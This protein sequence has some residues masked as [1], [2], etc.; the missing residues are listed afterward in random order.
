MSPK[1]I[2]IGF[3]LLMLGINQAATAQDTAETLTHDGLERTYRLH[4]PSSYDDATA[5]P[6][7]IALHPSGGNGE[8]MA[9]ITGLNDVAE[10][11]NFI[12][13][14]PEGPYQYWDYGAD[15]DEWEKVEGVLDDP[16]FVAALIDSLAASYTID[17]AR[18]YA[19]GY[20]NGA[21]MAFRMGCDLGDKLAAIGAVA[22][23]ISDDIS[24]ACNSDNPVSVIYLHGTEDSV[25]PWDGK[26]LYM[27]D[28]MFIATAFSAYD[29]A[30]FWATKNI[31]NPKP[32]LSQNDANPNDS[33]SVQRAE[34]Y[35]C[36]GDTSV[37][38]YGFTGAGHTW[39]LDSSIDTTRLIWDFFAAHPRAEEQSE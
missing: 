6:L 5:V 7:V 31:C 34:F 36:D 18:I 15:L 20:S 4:V 9:N 17:P 19:V 12:V 28:G 3:M 32:L 30:V 16:G 29:T 27:P 26:P 11:E 21:R 8:V 22:A 37:T 33:R 14:Y 2:L 10:I 24:S 39:S 25:T 13:A 38:F 23:T 35:E 1:L